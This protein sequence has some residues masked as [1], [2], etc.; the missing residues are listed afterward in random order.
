MRLCGVASTELCF[1]FYSSNGAKL[2]RKIYILFSECLDEARCWA[3]DEPVAVTGEGEMNQ[4]E[5]KE[6]SHSYSQ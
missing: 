2:K 4:T 5:T 6:A 3:P 1:N